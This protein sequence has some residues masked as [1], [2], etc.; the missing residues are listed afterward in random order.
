MI[1]VIWGGKL[2]SKDLGAVLHE[3][4]ESVNR[5]ET[6]RAGSWALFFSKFF[7]GFKFLL[8][9]KYNSRLKN[10][11]LVRILFK[12]NCYQFNCSYLTHIQKQLNKN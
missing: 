7:S 5:V 2:K 1:Y 6:R 12:C 8:I 10:K 4:V 3:S 9:N 11:N